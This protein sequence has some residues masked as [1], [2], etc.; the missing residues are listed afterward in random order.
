MANIVQ[1]GSQ[2]RFTIPPRH[3]W[4]WNQQ[5]LSGRRKDSWLLDWSVSDLFQLQS[6][7]RHLGTHTLY[8]EVKRIIEKLNSRLLVQFAGYV[9]WVSSTKELPETI[10]CQNKQII[11][12]VLICL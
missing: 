9:Y 4:H 1:R 6:L 3:G 2:Q 5:F 12:V 10:K 7:L 8:G 11:N